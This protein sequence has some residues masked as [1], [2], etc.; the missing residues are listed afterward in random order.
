MPQ[1]RTIE[2]RVLKREILVVAT[3][4]FGRNWKAYIGIVPGRNHDE[5]WEQVL[6]TGDTLDEKIARFLFPNF[7][8]HPYDR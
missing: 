6:A 8:K 3:F 7:S 2:V 1:N 4:T 5:E